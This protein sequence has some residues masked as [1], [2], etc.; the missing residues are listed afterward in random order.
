MPMLYG[1]DVRMTSIASGFSNLKPSMHSRLCTLFI[2]SPTLNILS[3]PPELCG[4]RILS[5]AA[6]LSLLPKKHLGDFV[7]PHV[8][9]LGLL[10]GLGKRDRLYPIS[11]QGGYHAKLSFF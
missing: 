8:H 3:R 5:I 7:N 4:L 10:H 9:G 2:S 6:F 1:G 11:L